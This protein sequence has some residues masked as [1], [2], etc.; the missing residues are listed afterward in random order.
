MVRS[1]FLEFVNRHPDK[2]PSEDAEKKFIE[3]T[4]AYE[5]LSNPQKRAKYDAYGIY[6]LGDENRADDIQAPLRSNTFANFFG[7]QFFPF[8]QPHMDE[9]VEVITFHTYREKILTNS[10]S[11][12]F[13]LLGISHF[14]FVCRQIQPL[15][16]KIASRYSDLGV[17]FGIANIQDDQ[18]LREELNVLHSPSILAVVDRKLSYFMRSEFTEN[19]IIDFLI[20]ALLNTGPLRSSPT[21]GLPGTALATPLITFVKGE[22]E[23]EQFLTGCFE[24][25]RPRTLFVQAESRPPLRFCLAAF[26][27]LDHHASGFIDA[28]N[29]VTKPILRRLGITE[30]KVSVIFISNNYFAATLSHQ[31]N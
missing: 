20:Q 4:K 5:V 13:M 24:D 8:G 29:V 3:I 16:S 30:S 6:D 17:I 22:V 11:A 25:S 2:N 27:A 14:C 9:N 19:T 12:P 1:E 26:R 7:G 28:R 10:R 23:L 18:A 31:V 21:L 15:W